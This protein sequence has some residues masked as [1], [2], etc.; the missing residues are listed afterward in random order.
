[1]RSAAAVKTTTEHLVGGMGCGGG[2]KREGSGFESTF[3][4]GW[5]TVTNH[6]SK[7]S[8]NLNC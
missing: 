2:A 3:L 6:A 5:A 8:L 1:M 7:I 4:G